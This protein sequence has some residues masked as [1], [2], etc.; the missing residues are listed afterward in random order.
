[1]TGT[2]IKDTERAYVAKFTNL[3]QVWHPSFFDQAEF[4]R[5]LQTAVQR[6]TPLTRPEVEAVLGDPGWEW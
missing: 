4:Q 3:D 5:L 2:Q 6:G 1:M